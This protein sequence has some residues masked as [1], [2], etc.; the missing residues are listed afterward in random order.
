MADLGKVFADLR[1][2]MAVYAAQLVAQKDDDSELYL[3]TKYL[4]KNKKPLF[5]GAVQVKKTY[6]S[7]HLMPVYAKPELLAGLSTELKARM[8]GKSCFNFTSSDAALI[9]ELE[10]LT[11]A[12]YASY[13]EQGFV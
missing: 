6:V 2:I 11:K 12:A 7:Y 13:A 9:K 4:Q 3:D 1:A 8:Q 5:F 10:D